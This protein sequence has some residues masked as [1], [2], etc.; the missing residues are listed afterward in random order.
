MKILTFS[1]NCTKIG[2]GS[3]K[4]DQLKLI[5]NQKYLKM[6]DFR[7]VSINNQKYLQVFK[8]KFDSN[9][10]YTIWIDHIAIEIVL[11]VFKSKYFD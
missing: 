8:S 10:I 7:I 4:I 3:I 6:F 5:I 2:L 9:T 11:I 1:L